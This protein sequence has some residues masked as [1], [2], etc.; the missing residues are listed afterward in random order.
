[1]QHRRPLLRPGADLLVR[2]RA[3][4]AQIGQ[5]VQGAVWV[6]HHVDYCQSGAEQTLEISTV[7]FKGIG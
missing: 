1:M 3:G 2:Q 7:E 4:Q 5:G 6:H